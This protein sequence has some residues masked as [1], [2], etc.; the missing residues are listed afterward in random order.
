MNVLKGST[1]DHLTVL[2]AE[3]TSG[4]GEISILQPPGTFALTPAT[5]VI[6]Q[7]IGSHQS[8]IHGNGIDWGSGTGC[9]AIAASMITAV[10]RVVGLEITPANVQAARQN[11]LLNQAESRVRFLLSDSYEPVA[12]TDRRTLETFKGQTHFILAN[13]PSSEGDDGFAFRRR[14]LEG[15]RP[16]LVPGGVVL[17]NISYQYGQE[18]I[19]QLTQQIP[20]FTHEGILTSTDWVPFDLQRADLMDCLEAYAKE[21]NRGGWKYLFAHP[22]TADVFL[23]ARSALANFQRTGLSP[24]TKWQTHLFRFTTG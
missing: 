4:L 13:P 5:L 24:L 1:Q 8:L 16:Y 17:L 7:A 19:E 20:G 14:V 3:M 2:T 18:R 11:A 10:D 9:L 21:E 15:A 23:D 6:L 12:E 22:E